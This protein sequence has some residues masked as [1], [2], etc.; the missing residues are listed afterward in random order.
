MPV[1]VSFPRSNSRGPSAKASANS[2][3]E[4]IGFQAGPAGSVNLT[5][6]N[7]VDE[8]KNIFDDPDSDGCPIKLTD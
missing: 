2:G 4:V 7:R 1:N 6:Q 8:T 5:F 3:V